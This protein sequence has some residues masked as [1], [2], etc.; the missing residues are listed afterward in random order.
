VRQA[1]HTNP[2]RDDPETHTMLSRPPGFKPRSCKVG[3]VTRACV[4]HEKHGRGGHFHIGLPGTSG[5]LAP[6]DPRWNRLDLP[7]LSLLRPGHV[8]P[9][10][11]RNRAPCRVRPGHHSPTNA[12]RP[13]AIR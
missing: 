3:I 1:A 13:H 7:P 5:I 10:L 8:P 6:A 9:P 4:A 2:R 11:S 12:L